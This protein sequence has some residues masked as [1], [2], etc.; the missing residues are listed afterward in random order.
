MTPDMQR[1]LNQLDRLEVWIGDLLSVERFAKQTKLQAKA[2]HVGYTVEQ[3]RLAL[4]M[5]LDYLEHQDGNDGP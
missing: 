3:L 2:N 5:L 4:E 1:T